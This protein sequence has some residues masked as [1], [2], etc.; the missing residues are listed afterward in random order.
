[1]RIDL[2]IVES[3]NHNV[4]PTGILD[5]HLEG[6]KGIFGRNRYFDGG[7]HFSYSDDNISRWPCV[8]DRVERAAIS[9]FYKAAELGNVKRGHIIFIPRSGVYCRVAF[10]EPRKGLVGLVGYRAHTALAQVNR[11]TTQLGLSRQGLERHMAVSRT[12]PEI[13]VIAQPGDLA[14]SELVRNMEGDPYEL[15]PENPLDVPNRLGCIKTKT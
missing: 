4:S 3:L 10:P 11:P 12:K 2:N 5:L 1:M 6:R 9:A 8:E 7:T 15:V 14:R 13:L